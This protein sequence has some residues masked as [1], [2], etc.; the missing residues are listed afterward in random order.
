[1][2]S[3]TRKKWNLQGAKIKLVTYY[4]WITFEEQNSTSCQATSNLFHNEPMAKWY[5]GNINMDADFIGD[6]LFP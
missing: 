2:N 6:T 4:N 5:H 3:I 1:M